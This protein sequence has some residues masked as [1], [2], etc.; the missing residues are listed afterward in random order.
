MAPQRQRAQVDVHLILRRGDDILLGQRINTGWADGQWHVPSGH[1]EDRESALHTLVRETGEEIGIA[2]DA[3][4]ARFAHLV[5]HYTESAR[6]AVFFEVTR[7]T[8]EPV[9]TE[10]DKCTG[11][12]WFPLTDLPDPLIPYAAQA[13]AHYSKGEPYSERGWEDMP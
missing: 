3:A 11:W 5:H 6:M 2:I 7:W 12:R 13:L 1:G 9:N 4:E 8:G 10:P